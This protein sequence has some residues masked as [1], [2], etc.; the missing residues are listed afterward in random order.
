MAFHPYPQVIREFCNIHRFGPPVRVTAPSA[1]SWI[2]HSVS[3]LIRRTERPVQTRF[4]CAYTYRLKLA[5]QTKSLTHYTKGTPSPRT[6]LGLRLFVGIRFQVY[7]TPLVGVLFTFPSRYW[8]TIGR[9]GVLRLGRWSSQFQ[10]GFHVSRPTQ[11]HDRPLPVRGY[12]PLRPD[13]PD[14]SGSINHATGLVR[15]RSPLLAES[16]L[17]S[18][19][20][21]TEMFHFPGFASLIGITPKSWVA[22]FGN[23][24]IKACSQLPVAYR[25][26]PRPSSPLDAKA[27]TECPSCA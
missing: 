2:D 26:V 23:P 24:R 6:N 13:F 11:G 19:P 14:G 17:M 7:F 8:C 20:P 3:G 1:C 27:S 12:H 15:V 10:T 9:R 18:F 21:G 16:R 5:R 25:S 4:R 22:P